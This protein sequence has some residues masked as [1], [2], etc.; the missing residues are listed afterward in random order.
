[1]CRFLGCELLRFGAALDFS[2]GAASGYMVR[3]AFNVAPQFTISEPPWF[4]QVR[5]V[6]LQ[7]D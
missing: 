2:S 7:R 1:M 3:D 4:T 5:R 6:E